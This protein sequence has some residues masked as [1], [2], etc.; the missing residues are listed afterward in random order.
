MTALARSASSFVAGLVEVLD[1]G[2]GQWQCEKDAERREKRNSP[3][4]QAAKR[5][6]DGKAEDAIA[7][8]ELEAN[9]RNVSVGLVKGMMTFAGEYIEEENVKTRQRIE[10]LEA[11]A[12]DNNTRICSVE[13]KQAQ[14]ATALETI[15]K[16][17]EELRTENQ[18]LKEELHV[19]SA[20]R[21]SGPNPAASSDSPP[22]QGQAPV[23]STNKLVF[24][25]E[26][27]QKDVTPPSERLH[28]TVGNLGWN[29][30]RDSLISRMKAVFEEA[31]I[32]PAGW[33]SEFC[34]S[35]TGSQVNVTFRSAFERR[36]AESKV[37]ALK[38]EFPENSQKEKP[39][40]WMGATK[41][42]TEKL[43]GKI[44]TQLKRAILDL[45][46]RKGTPDGESPLKLIAEYSEWKL[47]R[48]IVV[49]EQ[50]TTEVYPLVS[51]TN[52]QIR[53]TDFAYQRYS[54]LE[55]LELVSSW[56]HSRAV[57]RS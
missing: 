24:F 52:N 3:S 5:G 25:F 21:P 26:C 42:A 27:S 18:K 17:M 38:K 11:H 33:N 32:D 57:A 56:A 29:T 46:R 43:P 23:Q 44:V 1:K 2:A 10:K 50:T 45:E 6:K 16:G 15:T 51:V 28:A 31:R 48:D 35:Q 34:E 40:V 30:Q 13:N 7:Q 19:Q 47:K 53:W 54:E 55:N 14:Q 20:W 4:Q 9:V 39:C 36:S 37:F 49:E 12:S 8:V 41:T 22:A